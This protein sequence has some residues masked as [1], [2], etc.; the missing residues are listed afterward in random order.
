M[1]G[2][3]G[4]KKLGFGGKHVCGSVTDILLICGGCQGAVG[5]VMPQNEFSNSASNG[6][7]DARLVL[8]CEMCLA[9]AGVGQQTFSA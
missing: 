2:Y 6:P 1:S 8:E 7:S 9:E 4:T 5:G 3:T